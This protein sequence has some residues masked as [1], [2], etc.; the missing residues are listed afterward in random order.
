MAKGGH[1]ISNA[2]GFFT[3]PTIAVETDNEIDKHIKEELK[4]IKEFFP[5]MT[6]EELD[7]I[8]QHLDSLESMRAID[9]YCKKYI[10][11]NI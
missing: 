2:I 11:D 3:N 4:I 5:N 8:K 1:S 10:N 6:E 9:S 7:G